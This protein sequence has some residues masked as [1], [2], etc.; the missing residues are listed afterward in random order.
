MRFPGNRYR[1]AR[2]NDYEIDAK[3]LECDDDKATL[4]KKLPKSEKGET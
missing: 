1:M 2:G 3:R 4:E